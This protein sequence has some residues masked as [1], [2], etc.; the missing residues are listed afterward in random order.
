METKC[1][2]STAVRKSRS[3]NRWPPAVRTKTTGSVIRMRREPKSEAGRPEYP[4][5]QG[6]PPS[7]IETPKCHLREH[8]RL[9]LA[10]R[11]LQFPEHC[12]SKRLD[13]LAWRRTHRF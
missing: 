10:V 12:L 3:I 13:L 4:V 11:R 8:T 2:V 7:P 5:G 6:R 9:P 1:D